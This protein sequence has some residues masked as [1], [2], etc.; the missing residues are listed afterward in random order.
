MRLIRFE[1]GMLLLLG[2]AVS[3][4]FEGNASIGISIIYAA[5]MISESLNDIKIDLEK[6]WK[7]EKT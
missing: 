5:W 2:F 3:I 6:M 7:G 1:G 4:G